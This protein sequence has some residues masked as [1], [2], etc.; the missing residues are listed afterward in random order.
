[1]ATVSSLW[2]GKAKDNFTHQNRMKSTHALSPPS[3]NIGPQCW[4]RR[5]RWSWRWR[6]QQQEQCR[7]QSVGRR[8]SVGGGLGSPAFGAPPVILVAGGLSRFHPA[9]NS[10]SRTWADGN[11]STGTQRLPQPHTFCLQS[12]AC[13]DVEMLYEDSWICSLCLRLAGGGGGWKC[14]KL[15]YY[16]FYLCQLTSLRCFTFGFRIRD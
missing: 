10:H 15:R 6:R 2:Q 13:I 16:G 8:E 3:S 5:W 9:P 1:M 11:A 7:T 4:R 12:P 14:T